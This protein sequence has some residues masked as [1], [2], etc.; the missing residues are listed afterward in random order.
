MRMNNYRVV[1][2]SASPRRK[3]LLGQLVPLFSIRIAEV[4]EHCL[5]TSPTQYVMYTAGKKA[6]AVSIDE[7]ELLV[8]A[9]TIVY[10]EGKFLGKPVD[11][12]DAK[13]MLVMQNGKVNTVYTGVCLRTAHSIEFFVEDSAVRIDMTEPQRDHYIAG[14][15]A[16]DKAGAYGI[17]DP[18]MHAVLLSGSLSNVIGLPTEAL[19]EH[20]AR[21]G[22]EE[23]YV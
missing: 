5:L 6:M 8:S 19:A 12:V 23:K 21:Y 9:D 10:F 7:D 18:D 22:I 20:L 17:Q 15:Y 16:R 14:G 3:E 11:D 4:D 2:G 1:L 13:R